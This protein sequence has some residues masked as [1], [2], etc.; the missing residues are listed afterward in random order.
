MFI[1]IIISNFYLGAQPLTV[2]MPL[3]WIKEISILDLHAQYAICNI[4]LN[5]KLSIMKG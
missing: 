3:K 1:L 5:A 4:V 2:N